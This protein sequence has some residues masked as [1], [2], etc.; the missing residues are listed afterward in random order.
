M[1][2]YIKNQD[3]IITVEI[4]E[5]DYDINNTSH[6]E[7]NEPIS[8]DQNIL[9]MYVDGSIIEVNKEDYDFAIELMQTQKDIQA[10][11]AILVD[12]PN[13]TFLVPLLSEKKKTKEKK[14]AKAKK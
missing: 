11:E 14:L 1:Y 2:K 12:S 10:I 13:N 6:I 5:E 9:S 8:Q 3:N 4:N 7:L